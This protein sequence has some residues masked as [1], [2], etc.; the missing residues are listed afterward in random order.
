VISGVFRT[1]IC[2]ILTEVIKESAVSVLRLVYTSTLKMEAAG[3]S[4]TL[5]TMTP[6]KTVTFR[7]AFI[8]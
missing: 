3:S 2:E 6:Q 5:V 1:G 8:Y 4:E 7:N